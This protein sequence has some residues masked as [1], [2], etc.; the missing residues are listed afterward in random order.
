MSVLVS[1]LVNGASVR[2]I[3]V[4]AH[5]GAALGGY[6]KQLKRTADVQNA[7]RRFSNRPNHREGVR[8]RLAL[9]GGSSISPLE[10]E[11]GSTLAV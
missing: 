4:C 1:R 5:C 11:R 10:A 2:A 9:L 6:I 7:M 3:L 8:E